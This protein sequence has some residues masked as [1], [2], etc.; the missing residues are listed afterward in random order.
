MRILNFIINFS[1]RNIMEAK[2]ILSILIFK[3]SKRSSDK[4]GVKSRI[5]EAVDVK[6]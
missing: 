1:V 6:C 4:L 2:T 5:P 3:K